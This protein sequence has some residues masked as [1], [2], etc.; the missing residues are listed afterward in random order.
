MLANEMM[1]LLLLLWP[2]TKA[3][4]QQPA[5]AAYPAA[6]RIYVTDIYYFDSLFILPRVAIATLQ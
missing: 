4:W 5:A 1:H 3:L 6:E 2:L